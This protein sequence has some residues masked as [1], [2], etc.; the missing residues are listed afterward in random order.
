MIQTQAESY[1]I[2]SAILY[3]LCHHH[4]YIYIYIYIFQLHILTQSGVIVWSKIGAYYI[5]YIH[6]YIYI[7]FCYIF[8]YKV[9]LSFGT[10]LEH[11]VKHIYIYIFLY[12]AAL[13]CDQKLER[14]LL[15]VMSSSNIQFNMSHQI[16]ILIIII[17]FLS[18]LLSYLLT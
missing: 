15:E 4:I 13:L 1:R 2:S 10:K 14:I 16:I 6:I 8:F 17:F 3:Y 12:K 11:I 9:A 5:L 18:Y 7:Y